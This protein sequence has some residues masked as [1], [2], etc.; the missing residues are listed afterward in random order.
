M[1]ETAIQKILS[2]HAGGRPLQP[3]ELLWARVDWA[4]IDDVQWPIFRD[5]FADLGGKVF[6]RERVIAIADHY[7]PP[8]DIGQAETLAE[9][10][11]FAESHDIPHA[12]FEDGIKHQ[13]LIEKGLVKPGDLLLATDSHTPTAGA[14]G[15]IGVGVGPTEV[16]VAFAYG[17]AWLRVPQTVRIVLDGAL[18]AMVFAKDIALH[19][20]GREGTRFGNY[21]VLEYAGAGASG[22]RLSER[23]TLCNMATEMGTKAAFFELSEAE[24]ALLGRR[25]VASDP[26]APFERE[27]RV[28]LDRLEPLVAFPHLPSNVDSVTRFR[29]VKVDQA[30]IGSCANATFDD[31]AIAAGILRGKRVKRGVQMIVSPSSRG[32][33]QRAV[34]EGIVE[35]LIDAGA[36]VTNTGC[37]ACAGGHIGVLGPRQVRISSQNRN[38]IGRAGHRDSKIYLASPAVVAASAITGYIT[39]PREVTGA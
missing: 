31:L 37:G 25:P 34:R 33:Y 16:A 19:I 10:R 1:G 3:G 29:D 23:L 12:F 32:A 14:A 36:V 27:I 13:V 9:L 24:A 6:D 35:I 2:A 39:D 5:V 22:M 26:D 4:C 28:D 38:F 11:A 15:A 20:L 17:E 30:F 7:L 8:S 18:P 21:R